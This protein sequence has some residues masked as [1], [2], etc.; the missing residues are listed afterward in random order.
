MTTRLEA[1][2]A[3]RPKLVLGPVATTEQ[4]AE[5]I[6][7]QTGVEAI[8]AQVVL[9][10]LSEA[11]VFFAQQGK[12]VRV[13]G[14]NTYS[15]LIDLSGEFDCSPRLDRKVILA[16]NQPDSFSGKIINR[17]NIGKATAELVALWNAAHPDD[18]VT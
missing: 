10:Q 15:P 6:A 12:P 3:L 18:A 13:D 2:N 16:L 4:L 14:L 8:T 9:A 1:V 5:F 17:E 11:V 7:E